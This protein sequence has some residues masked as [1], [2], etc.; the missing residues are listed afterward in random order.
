MVEVAGTNSGTPEVIRQNC[1]I[2]GFYN[3]RDVAGQ[4]RDANLL[5]LCNT[6]DTYQ[7][8]MKEGKLEIR[9]S[10]VQ[11]LIRRWGKGAIVLR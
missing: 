7:W 10:E 11:Q 6:I 1:I 4:V 2:F 9:F 8:W 5:I 3:G